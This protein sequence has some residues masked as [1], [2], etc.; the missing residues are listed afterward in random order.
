MPSPIARVIALVT[1]CAVAHADDLEEVTRLPARDPAEALATFRLHSGFRLEPLAVEP[2]V[3]S[4]VAAAFDED[5]RLY[6]VEMRGYPYPESKPIGRVRRLEDRDGDGRYEHS[7]VFLDELPWPTG[8]VCSRGGV[9]VCAAPD[10]IYAADRDGD[11]KAEVPKTVFTG[12]GTGNVQALVNGLHWGPDGWIYGVS[13]GNG[14]EI[15]SLEHPERPAVS[16][17]GRD[18]RFRP[19]DG[20]LETTTGGGQFG[21]AFD[22]FGRRFTCNNSNHARQV[23]IEARD[24]DRNPALQ[25]ASGLADIP[26]EGPAAPVY[27]I[28]PAEPWRVVRT[29]QRA[30]DPEMVKRL[31]PTELV[32]IGFFT[33]ATGIT[34]YR[35]SA[36][37]PEFRGNLFVGAVGGNLVHRKI[38]RDHG[39]RLDAIRADQAREFLASTDTWFRP[40]NFLNTPWGTLLILDMYRETIEHPLSIPEPIKAR[41]DLTSGRDR[42]RLYDLVSNPARTRK[43]SRLGGIEPTD[44]VKALGHADSWQRETAQRLLLERRD[45]SAVPALRTLLESRPSAVARAHALWGLRGLGAATARDVLLGLDDIDPNVREVAVREARSFISDPEIVRRLTAAADDAHPRVR[46]ATAL[47]LGDS[48]ETW[49]LAPL[50]SIA[51]RDAGDPWTRLAVQSSLSGRERELFLVLS[52]RGDEAGVRSWLIEI[53]GILGARGRADEIKTA[54]DL[55][56]GPDFPGGA[57]IPVIVAV[58]RTTARNG[59][60]L[61]R[62]GSP[63]VLA[64]ILRRAR[65]LG[66]DRAVFAGE[67]AE[68]VELIGLIGIPGDAAA[69][70][71]VADAREPTAIQIAA[72]R[73]LSALDAPETTD[74]L[75][76]RRSDLGPGPRGEVDEALASRK[77]RALAFLTAIRAGRVSP[78]DLDP[79]RRLQFLK[80]PDAEIRL[81]AEATLSTGTTGNRAAIVERYRTR[82]AAPGDP[83]RGREVVRRNCIGCHRAEGQ[84]A[85]VGPDLATVA[86]R[87]A[88]DLLVHILDPNREVA[89]TYL[90][91]NVAT[92]DGLILSGRIVEESPAAVT[93]RRAEGA[94]DVVPRSRIE[95]LRST[96]LSLMPEGLE[97]VIDP[98]A[99]SDLIAYLRKRKSP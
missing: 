20:A 58:A 42:G 44:L 89:P 98:T 40:V 78:A 35:G 21:H 16:V 25:G 33:S 26:V 34:I 79:A 73:A 24:I 64:E 61:R 65:K 32:P 47:A 93:L 60:S 15:R 74:L 88:E 30:A 8:I 57:T 51:V 86:S 56:V 53:A 75:I 49:T 84:G 1:L 95:A 6:V 63:A 69:L 36:Y 12:F 96:G 97:S 71:E 38:L 46:L 23:V 18:F 50:A 52:R 41:L 66:S 82:L 55:A 81:M 45:K 83:E 90:N 67:R 14:G 48:R 68:A 94:T 85:D 2:L 91:Y 31:P 19:E 9:F 62:M 80:H 11:G 13:G 99:M 27:R 77:T 5:G 87:S 7:D 54:L 59:G 22:D 92:T 28:S 29:R 17:R 10:I 43:A 37:P 39:A 4:P 72:V 76:D 70:A 3:A